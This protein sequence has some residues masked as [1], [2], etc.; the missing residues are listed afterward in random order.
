MA[1]TDRMFEGGG[2]PSGGGSGAKSFG[3]YATGGTQIMQ[4]KG[5]NKVI[6]IDPE[7]NI[8]SRPFVRRELPKGTQAGHTVTSVD[9]KT[10]KAK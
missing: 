4:P 3:P 9:R 1:R 6:K 2:A 10:G 8:S 5:T 7:G